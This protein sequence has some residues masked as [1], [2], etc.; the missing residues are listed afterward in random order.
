MTTATTLAL[1]LV[2]GSTAYAEPKIDWSRGLV[3]ADA[4]GVADRHAPNPAVARG[5]SRRVAEAAAK[6]LIA[7][8]LDELPLAGGGKVGDRAADADVKVRL[9][10]A[11]DAAMT[12]SA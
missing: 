11:V 10:R 12:L 4:V 1:I 7:A 5:T 2:L 6:K 3:I 8:K 9:A